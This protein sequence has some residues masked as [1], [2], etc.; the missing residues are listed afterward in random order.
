MPYPDF[1]PAYDTVPVTVSGSEPMQYTVDVPSQGSNTF[2]SFIMYVRTPD[3]AVEVLDVR[4]NFN[5]DPAFTDPDGDGYLNIND[6][7]PDDSTE[8]VDTDGDGIGNNADTDDDNDLISDAEDLFPLSDY[9]AS[10]ISTDIVSDSSRF[11]LVGYRAGAID[12]PAV[13]LAYNLP[14]WQL[15]GDGTFRANG[16]AG[17]WSSVGGGYLLTQ[18]SPGM[19]SYPVVNGNFSNLNRDMIADGSQIEVEVRYAWRLGVIETGPETWRLAVSTTTMY[20]ATDSSLVMDP[21]KPVLTNVSPFVDDQMLIV[22]PDVVS[23]PYATTD[24]L[25]NSIISFNFINDGNDQAIQN[26]PHCESRSC[27]DVITL[28]GD[29]TAITKYSQRDANW[30]LTG[31][32]V[33]GI[34]FIDDSS[35]MYLERLVQGADVDTV[36]ITSDL[37][38]PYIASV[39]M[40]IKGASDASTDYSAFFTGVPLSS[41]FYVTN[42][43]P[44][45]A[46]RAADGSLLD[47]FGVALNADGTGV[48]F[49]V[50]SNVYDIE[51]T[52][53]I[54]GFYSARDITWT[55][56]GNVIESALCLYAQDLGAGL[57]CGFKQ[58]RT[59]DVVLATATRLYVHETLTYDVDDDFDGVVNRREYSISRVNFYELSPDY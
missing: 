45:Y 33:L 50:S 23:V 3:V 1:D 35:I 32:G 17:I 44:S 53:V 29:G 13:H 48:R 25:S 28:F 38:D 5:S 4:V 9:A 59:W 39:G 56:T 12:N 8:W 51:G 36:M 40:L 16:E 46:S 6:A 37:A 47:N 30:F 11:G 41:G 34:E 14:A 24:E 31:Q 2:E 22:S 26:A 7:F 54:D 42:D 55:Q 58:T 21:A 18:T 57:V 43:D 27:S 10:L 19:L 20:F 49:S 52:Q 15:F